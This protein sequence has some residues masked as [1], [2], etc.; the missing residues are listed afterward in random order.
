MSLP[1][2]DESLLAECEIHT[3]R[4]SGH[5]G[6]NVNKRDT[7]VRLRHRPT[8][9]TVVCQHERSQYRNKQLALTDLRR[10]L[11]QRFHRARPR[12]ATAIPKGVRNRILESKKRLG[13]KK[14]WRRAV[15]DQ[16]D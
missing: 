13:R 8:G 7:A 14:Q 15:K 4:A 6:Q 11:R 1:K 10:K 2:S 12:I 5:G 3:F 9:L 16:D